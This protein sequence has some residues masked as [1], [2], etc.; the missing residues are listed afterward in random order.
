MRIASLNP[1]EPS[2]SLVSPNESGRLQCITVPR[3]VNLLT[4]LPAENGAAV[5]VITVTQYGKVQ[6][7]L[8]RTNSN[9]AFNPDLIE[10]GCFGLT[11]RSLRSEKSRVA[12]QAVMRYESKSLA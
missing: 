1:F 7:V 6:S 11:R 10:H 3:A 9:N 2:R 8:R 5:S 4:H 12:T